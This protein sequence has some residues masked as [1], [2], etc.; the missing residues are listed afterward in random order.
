MA[1][2]TRTS[3]R[4]AGSPKR[5]LKVSPI[6]SVFVLPQLETNTE[7]DTTNLGKN[8]TGC[9][10]KNLGL[11]VKINDSRIN[12]SQYW[13]I[14]N[15]KY[16]GTLQ[17]KQIRKQET[18]G[19]ILWSLIKKGENAKSSTQLFL[20]ITGAELWDVKAIVIPIVVGAFGTVH[21]QL[22]NHLK[23]IGIPIVLSCLQKQHYQE[24]LS[25]LG[26]FLTFQRVGNSQLSRHFARHV[27]VMLYSKKYQLL[28]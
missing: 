18:E 16:F 13:K 3:P 21:E 5:K 14:A 6:L 4:Y 8:Y 10:A 24:Q 25:S 11:N 9:Y 17:S 7:R 19:Q 2:I 28:F 23:A 20:E 26:G 27:V 1:L 15:V 22:E 12:Q